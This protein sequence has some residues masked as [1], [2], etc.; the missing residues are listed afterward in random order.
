MNRRTIFG[1]AVT[2]ALS[3]QVAL[4][5]VYWLGDD[6]E[7]EQ[8]EQAQAPENDRALYHSLRPPFVV[9][10][11]YGERQF[12]LQANLAVMAHDPAAIDAVIRHSPLIRAE[13]IDYLTDLDPRDIQAKEGKQALLDGL[14]ELINGALEREADGAAIDAVLFNNLV[15]Q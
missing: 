8:E 7:A 9:T 10:L 13:V 1:L 12:M 14:T 15:M 6:G 5:A 3:V 2:L 4:V 11:P